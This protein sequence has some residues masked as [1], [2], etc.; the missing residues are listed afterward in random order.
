MRNGAGSR[1][2]ANRWVCSKLREVNFE[3]SEARESR[4]YQSCGPVDVCNFVISE[5][6][7]SLPSRGCLS[8]YACVDLKRTPGERPGGALDQRQLWKLHLQA[9]CVRPLKT[10]LEPGDD[11]APLS[12]HAPFCSLPKRGGFR[13][14][15]RAGETVAMLEATATTATA[16]ELLV[17]NHTRNIH[18]EGVT[19]E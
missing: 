7:L 6:H 3:S 11:A 13:Y 12:F 19:F 9:R 5:Y 18:W 16:Q 17:V 10:G 4:C 14:I 8:L 1:D 15:L 2:G